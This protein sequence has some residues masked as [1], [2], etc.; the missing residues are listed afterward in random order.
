MGSS[1]D[2]VYCVHAGMGNRQATGAANATA[3]YGDAPRI[4][5]V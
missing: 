4:I 5:C 3:G 2:P 1:R